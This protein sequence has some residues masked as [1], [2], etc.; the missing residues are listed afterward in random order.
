MAEAIG[1]FQV[2]TVEEIPPQVL[3]TRGKYA[4]V[5]EE[6]R[7]LAPKV[8]VLDIGDAKK[9]ATTMQGLRGYLKRN[10]EIENFVVARQLS[11]VFI[12]VK[13]NEKTGPESTP[14]PRGQD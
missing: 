8:L 3:A 10:N 5:V 11:K 6:A 2:E 9:A 4:I 14:A 7:K 13:Q 1:G 12:Q